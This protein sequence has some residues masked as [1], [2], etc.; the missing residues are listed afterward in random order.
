[1]AYV[2]GETTVTL[3]GNYSFAFQTDVGKRGVV[4]PVDG[5][6]TPAATW[7]RR[8]SE[9]RPMYF[10]MS[11]KPQATSLFADGYQESHQ[12]KQK[13]RRQILVVI[14]AQQLYAYYLF[15]IYFLFNQQD[16]F[17]YSNNQQINI[18]Q[19]QQYEQL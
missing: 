15:T 13:S 5:P 8:P 14:D 18:R 12:S 10:E 17:F 7:L 1:M 19:I 16:V 11:C 4:T 9:I 6:A 2:T 3:R